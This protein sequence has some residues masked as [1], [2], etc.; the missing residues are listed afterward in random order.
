MAV[1]EFSNFGMRSV[2]VCPAVIRVATCDRQR[3]GETDMYVQT[4]R[5]RER[6]TERQRDREGYCFRSVVLVSSRRK[7]TY[8]YSLRN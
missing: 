7:R 4:D 8:A 3:E 1:L 2:S 6:M 5:Q